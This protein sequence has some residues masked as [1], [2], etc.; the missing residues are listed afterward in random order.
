[1]NLFR[2]TSIRGKQMILI[3]VTSC[4]VLLLACA[5]LVTYDLVTFRL[6]MTQHLASLAEVLANNSTSAL[7]FNDP[8]V[9]GEVLSALRAE[10]D[11]LAATIY[12]KHGGVF[13]H[14]HQPGHD[15]DALLPVQAEGHHFERG[16]LVLF[17]NISVGDD[18]V[19]VICLQSNLQALSLRLRQYVM[20]VIGIVL[21]AGLAALVLSAWLQGF[22]TGPILQLAQATRSVARQK[23]YT[24]R[25]PK[26]NHDELGLLID[27]FNEMLAQI[28]AQDAAL[29]LAHADLERRVAK[30]T[31]ELQR[32]V[33]ERQR[34][35]A[36]LR[37]TALHLD[38]ILKALPAGVCILDARTKEILDINPAA[39]NM[40]GGSRDEIVGKVCHLFI[41]PA[42]EGK[43]PITDCGQTVDNSERIL[44]GASGK[45][46]PILKSV[47]RVNLNGRDCLVETFVD[48]T[49]R[50]QAE[51]RL[52]CSQLELAE[53]NRQL[54]KTIEH[55]NQMAAQA[56]MANVAKSEFLANMSHEI[57]TPMNGVIGMTGLL[58]DTE[59]TAEQRRYAEVVRNSGNALL[60][61]IND[62]L[63]FSKIEAGK[64][65]LESLDFDLRA[66]LDD[67]SEMMALRADEKGVEF[68]SLVEPQVPSLLR[69]DP[70]RLRQILFNLAG[71]AIKF[72][73]AGEVAIHVRLEEATDTKVRLRFEVSDTGIGI[74]ADKIGL[75]FQA[76]GQA[77]GSITRK[78]GG[79]GLGL[80]ISKQLS[81]MMGGEIG[82]ESEEGKGSSFWFTVVLERQ[83]EPTATAIIH[84]RALSGARVLVV[85][86]SET[87]RLVLVRLL[88]GWQCRWAEAEDAA[89]ALRQ[90]REAA[91]AGD[92]FRIAL[93]DM[94]M[95]EV[96]GETLGQMV[97]ADPRLAPTA[98]VMLTSAGQRKDAARMKQAGFNDFLIKPVRASRL[99][100]CLKAVS[101]PRPPVRP[102]PQ[103]AGP[104]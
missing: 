19:G 94:R 18:A 30:R 91:D 8:K 95:P 55:A 48:I 62:I 90:L 56:E 15:Q 14:Y 52:Q 71:N 10:P 50:K 54:E 66:T 45:R 42:E 4:T 63:D 59:L 103:P 88:E 31:Q 6:S 100:D 53:A 2:Q 97:K 76:F 74:P 34:A 28:Q 92:P 61:V 73:A 21:A 16:R 24:V 25:V 78:F 58:L 79:T 104:K 26:E 39:V 13:A 36:M 43:C 40:A 32:E 64:L 23:D 27:D 98:L 5:G 77:D 51:E 35:E 7:D 82:V 11:I 57:R 46:L 29:Q 60:A 86:D 89:S 99:L 102:A 20:I 12:T 33:A 67:V 3:M 22:I 75:L 68:A 83:P 85:D 72:T 84:S 80:A 69:G 81:Q 47:I 9:A 65:D 41:C 44:I 17:R 96:D 37:V 93:L 70:G 38:T 1:M 101:S 87:N 49:D